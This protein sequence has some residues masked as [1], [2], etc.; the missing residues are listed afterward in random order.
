MI[1]ISSKAYMAYEEAALWQLK[2]YKKK[3]K[4]ELFVSYKICMK[5]KQDLDIDNAMASIN[6]ILEKSGIIENDKNIVD[7]KARKIRGSEKWCVYVDI[8]EL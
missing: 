7:V 2:K 1:P 5:G 8:V 3:Y 4:G 6:D